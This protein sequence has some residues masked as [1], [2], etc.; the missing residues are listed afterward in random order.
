MK[1]IQHPV[2]DESRNAS[3]NPSIRELLAGVDPARRRFLQGSAG[4][5]SLAA[6]GGLT[7]SGLVQAMGNGESAAAPAVGIGFAALPPALACNG[8]LPDRVAVAAGHRVELLVAWGDPILPGAV[9]FRADASNTA[10][11]QAGQYGMHTDGMHFFPLASGRSERGL[12]CANNEYTHEAVLYP[13]GQA[14]KDVL[15]DG[16][17]I[18]KCRKSQAAHGVSICE[19]RLVDGRWQVLA[20]SPRGRR[21]TANTPMRVAG[22]AAGHA[23]LRAR[24]YRIG[25]AGSQPTGRQLDGYRAFGTMN[26]CANGITPWGTYLSCE[27]NWNGNFGASGA[28]PAPPDENGRLYRRYGLDRDGKGYHWHRVDPRFDLS[29]NPLE[30]NLFGW[31]VEIDPFAPQSTPVKRTALGR[32]KHESAQ[33]VLDQDGHLA[34]YMGDDE[35][36]EYLYKFVCARRW[37]PKRP[38]D[39]TTMLDEGTLYVARFNPGQR[40]EWVALQPGTPGVDGRPL[41]QHPQ[42]AGI[43]DSEVQARILIKTRM[44]ADAVGATMMDRPEWTGARPRHAGQPEI[45]IYCTL[46]NNERRGTAPASSNPADGSAAAA[47][48]RPPVDGANPRGDN[49]YGHIIRWREDGQSV[50]ATAFTWEIF[51]QCGDQATTKAARADNDYRGDM[52]GEPAG[53]ADIGAPDG[54][55]FDWFGRL[56]VQ[57]DQAG[58]GRG[59]WQHLGANSLS[60]AD[61]V[62][63]R[64]RRFL[65]GPHGCEVTG[66]TMTP[67]G[68]HLFVGIQHPGDEAP[69]DDPTR[70]SGWP[71]S[72][73]P[74]RADGLALPSGRPRSGVVVISREDGGIVGS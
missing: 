54:L 22:P 55:W 40:G 32:F 31:V 56:W 44:A 30:P 73:W 15:G 29:E 19:L 35:K 62:S 26:N 17:T 33:Y 74:R 59:D 61:P 45:E 58:D 1:G 14:G 49:I 24:E 4:V 64:F 65:T 2:N 66:I 5:A 21:I 8:R 60:C 36:N 16:F 23:L 63:R 3:G 20:D 27:E 71:A 38:G 70:Y 67:D 28:L 10:A 7:L 50:R 25:A 18:E 13:A 9:P 57:T 41:R 68:R 39:K 37:N 46:T 11:E 43:D 69:A 53:S 48:A 47:S 52:L 51:V 42:F 34:F 72:Q 6:A 12:L